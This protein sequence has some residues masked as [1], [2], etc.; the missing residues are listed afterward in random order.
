VLSWLRRYSASLPTSV[1]LPTPALPVTA[2]TSELAGLV[3]IAARISPSCSPRPTTLSRRESACRSPVR[4][5]LS[6]SSSM[7]AAPAG[8]EEFG[9]L[10]Q[11]RAG[12]KH[13]R[14]AQLQQLGNVGFWND[15]ADQHADVPQAGIIQ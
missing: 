11:R 9:N 1:L 5:R 4:S 13:S 12:S 10:R 8:A 7:R 6:R 3:V 15:A 14:H 2:T